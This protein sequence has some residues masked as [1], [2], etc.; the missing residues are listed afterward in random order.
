MNYAK[1]MIGLVLYIGNIIAWGVGGWMVITSCGGMTYG[2]LLTFIA[3]MN[4]VFSPLEFFHEFVDGGL[5]NRH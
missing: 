4:M 1:P 3:Y 2:M 5:Y